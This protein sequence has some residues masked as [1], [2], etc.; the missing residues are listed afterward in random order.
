MR[1][2]GPVFDFW[3][4]GFITAS[5][6]GMACASTGPGYGWSVVGI[7]LVDTVAL[8]IFALKSRGERL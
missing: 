7:G 4:A 1:L 5:G 3:I 2:L 8:I 6:L